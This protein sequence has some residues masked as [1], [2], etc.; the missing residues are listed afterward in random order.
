M[1]SGGEA[2]ASYQEI[3]ERMLYT[4]VNAAALCLEEKFVLQPSDF[5]VTMVLGFG[6]PAWRGGLMHWAAEIG[7]DKIADWLKH[8][9]DTVSP[10]FKPTEWL[11]HR[12]L[13]ADDP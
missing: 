8:Y 1:A 5:D 12:A 11:R 7:Y 9:A 3:L 2:V 4:W 13:N 6:F 10:V